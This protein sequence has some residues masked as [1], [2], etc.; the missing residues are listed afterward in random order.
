MKELVNARDALVKDRVAALNRQATAVSPLI[1][2]QLAQRLRQINGQIEAIDKHLKLL[3]NADSDLCQRFDILTS[4]PGL[5]E[6]T[7]NVLVVETT[8]ARASRPPPGC[9]SRRSRTCRKGQWQDPWQAI[10][11]RRPPA[12]QTGSLHARPQR[13]PMQP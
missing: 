8:R 13:H 1:K 11:P 9:Q 7:A 4:I 5:G 10:H 3:R 12:S 2:R 6:A